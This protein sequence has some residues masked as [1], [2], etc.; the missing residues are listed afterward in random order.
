[1]SGIS[2][3]MVEGGQG[4]VYRDCPSKIREY[5][6]LGD[7]IEFLVMPF[8]LIN[9]SMAFVDLMNRVF[10]TVCGSFCLSVHRQHSCV[11]EI[12]GKSR[13]TPSGSVRDF[14]KRAVVCETEQ[15]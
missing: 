12:S 9:A 6:F 10:L 11:F 4:R 1:M 13:H 3:L 14:K 2:P 5:E 7:L 15:V 8:R